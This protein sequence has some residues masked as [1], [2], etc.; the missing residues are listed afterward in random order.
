MDLKATL[1]KKAGPLPV[2]GWLVAGGAAFLIVR[3]LHPGASSTATDSTGSAPDT[4]AGGAGSLGGS[5]I[6][7]TTAGDGASLS[8]FGAVDTGVGV[9]LAPTDGGPGPQPVPTSVIAGPRPAGVWHILP[10]GCPPGFHSEGGRC[11]PG[12]YCPP[13]YTWRPWLGRCERNLAG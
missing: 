6:D 3:R 12:R 11:V 5:P 8:G 10:G 4:V 2:W 9:A 7:Y 13:G 1:T